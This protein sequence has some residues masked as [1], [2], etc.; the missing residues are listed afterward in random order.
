MRQAVVCAFRSRDRCL[1]VRKK[2]L[3]EKSRYTTSSS[4]VHTKNKMVKYNRKVDMKTRNSIYFIFI[5][6]KNTP[7]HSPSYCVGNTVLRYCCR[8]NNKYCL[9]IYTFFLFIC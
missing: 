5:L 3:K 9:P 7:R 4:L 6:D 2:K 1:S 8:K